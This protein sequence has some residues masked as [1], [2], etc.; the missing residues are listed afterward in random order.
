MRTRADELETR[1]V[2]SGYD[3]AAPSFDRHRPLPEGVPEAIRQAI[4]TCLDIASPHLLDLGAGTGRIGGA[5][6]AAN[7]D[8]VGI[9]LSL[10]MLRE[11]ACR[12]DEKGGGAPRLVQA[13]GRFLP[14]PDAA[15]D[16]VML[17]QIF[18]AMRSWRRL[19]G[20]AR[21]VLRPHGSLVLGKATAPPDG[22]DAQMKRTLTAFLRELGA[23]PEHTNAREEVRHGLAADAER[24]TRLTAAAW[25]AE[26]TPQ[27][28]LERHRTG[29][30]FSALPTP[31]QEQALRRLSAWAVEKFGSLAA[32][33]SE[34]HAFELDVFRF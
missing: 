5:F 15:F 9:D 32:P 3:A 20:E 28:F 22:M 26:R 31:I 4:L 27:G 6:V 21:R 18:G 7:D 16:A 33:F 30:R 11:F 29:A 12:R 23:G 1:T 25:N 17:I 14:F 8:Y 2:A 24:C 19:V 10:G 34:R 13:D